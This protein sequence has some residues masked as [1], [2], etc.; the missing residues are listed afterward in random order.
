MKEPNI[1]RLKYPLWFNILFYVLTVVAP[2]VL[3]MVQGFNSPN[4]A[5]KVSFG[6]ICTL[7]ITWVYIRKFVLA[8]IEKR[9]I[10]EKSSLEHDYSI[11]SGSSDKIKY[12][13]FTN[14]LWLNLINALHIALIGILIGLLAVGIQ[15]SCI[16]ARGSVYIVALLYMIAYG[17]K[18]I[19]IVVSRNK[20]KEGDNTNG[21]R[22]AKKNKKS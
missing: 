15:A 6:V 3:M 11:E 5:F 17:I 21:T 4:T 16:K 14:E 13:W 8:N 22:R 9:L 2:I 1:K 12:L 20:G 19:Y 10:N 18:F 7:L